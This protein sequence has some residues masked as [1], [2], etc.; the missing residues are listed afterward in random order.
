MA[1]FSSACVHWDGHQSKKRS[2]PKMWKFEVSSLAPSAQAFIRLHLSC[3]WLAT[4]LKGL[5]SLSIIDRHMPSEEFLGSLSQLT[6]LTRL[7]INNKGIEP[8]SVCITFLG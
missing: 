3:A 7:V 4:K 1:L 6:G 5:T 8:V 2:K